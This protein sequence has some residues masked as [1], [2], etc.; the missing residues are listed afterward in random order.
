MKIHRPQYA[1]LTLV[2]H[3]VFW[4]PYILSSY[5]NSRNSNGICSSCSAPKLNFFVIC[6]VIFVSL[7]V[8]LAPRRIESKGYREY[9]KTEQGNAE[10]QKP[11]FPAKE[12]ACRWSKLAIKPH[13]KT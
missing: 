3:F 13:T 2:D 8:G 10:N 12:S 1:K 4:A 11:R 7:T 5:S 6:R 9:G